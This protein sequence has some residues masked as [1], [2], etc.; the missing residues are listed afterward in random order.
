MLIATKG[1]VY[2][3]FTLPYYK[4][5]KSKHKTEG[6]ITRVRLPRTR[7]GELFAV[8]DQLLGASRIRV[9]CEDG[10]SRMGRIPGKLKKRMWIR[11]GDL[12]IVKPWD[13]QQEKSDIKYR[14][15]KTQ[16]SYLKRRGMIPGSIDVF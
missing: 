11:E 13:F 1:V 12:L 6:E 7:D 15:T 14:Y 16:S 5:R 3:R 10:K 4:R 9:M 8:A 2:L